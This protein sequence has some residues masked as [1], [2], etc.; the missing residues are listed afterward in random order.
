MQNNPG[1][2]ICGLRNVGA[3]TRAAYSIVMMTTQGTATVKKKPLN[4]RADSAPRQE[5]KMYDPAEVVIIGLDTDDGHAHWGYDEESNKNPVLEADVLFTYEHGVIQNVLGRRDGDKVVIV[6]GRGRTRQLREANVRRKKD[7]Q[8]PWFLPVK[9]VQGDARKMLVLKHGENSHRREQSPLA[10][11]KQAAELKEQFPEDQAAMIMGLGVAQFRSLLKL[12]DT[13]PAVQKALMT[14]KL[15][16]T[17]AVELSQLSEKDQTEK[18]ATILETA[19]ATGGKLTTRDVKAK[20]REATGKVLAETP[21]G[22]I[23]KAGSILDKLDDDCTKDDLWA[24]IK[25]IRAALKL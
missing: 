23:K 21:M 2:D 3:G 15:H 9:I 6:A 16:Q 24:A 4:N 7:G 22:R 13:A 25:K 17:A 11:A 8:A 12:N 1:S 19:A 5:V 10:R 18:L 14:G 20:V